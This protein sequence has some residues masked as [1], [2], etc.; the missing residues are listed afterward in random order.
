MNASQASGLR[1]SLNP[2]IEFYGSFKA[3]GDRCSQGGVRCVWVG[4]LAVREQSVLETVPTTTRIPDAGR[5]GLPPGRLLLWR[6]FP[7]LFFSLSFQARSSSLD[8]SGLKLLLLLEKTQRKGEGANTQFAQFQARYPRI[9]GWA[10]GVAI[11]PWGARG[12]REK[13][14]A[15]ERGRKTRGQANGRERSQRREAPAE[16]PHQSHQVCSL[17][18]PDVCGS[19]LDREPARTAL[20]P[21][22]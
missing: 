8:H 2:L 11:H 18:V 4:P 13:E 21:P 19:R 16:P 17:G 7:D 1:P 10:S 5:G 14:G 20:T 6:P 15:S 3:F 9:T 12:D 22:A